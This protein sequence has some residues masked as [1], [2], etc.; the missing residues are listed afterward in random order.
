MQTPIPHAID[1]STEHWLNTLRA[2]DS[3]ATLAN[4]G[5]GPHAYTTST[6]AE[7]KI[8]TNASVVRPWMPAV[9]SSVVKVSE[10]DTR[11]NS[12][13]PY[14]FISVEAPIMVSTRQPRSRRLSANII[15]GAEP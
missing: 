11:F 8:V 14:N 7:S 1:S 2:V 12:S 10:V 9:P 5:I 4:M 3:S 13:S 15:N 6:C